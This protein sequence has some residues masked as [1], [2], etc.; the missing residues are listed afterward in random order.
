MTNEQWLI[1]L[2]GI[3]PNGG[4]T[5]IWA[6]ASMIVVMVGCFI[7]L[8][9]RDYDNFKN[10]ADE[11]YYK[12]SI[13]HK[14]GYWKITIPAFLFFAIMLSNL[15]PDKRTFMC[16]IAAPYVVE[17][18]KT[19]MEQLNDKTS[20]LHKLNKMLDMSLDKAIQKLEEPKK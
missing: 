15:I 16:I 2:Y 12:K 7:L 20:K 4:W 6:I 18:G 13:F 19:V 14:L 10:P 17:G 5:V 11:W 9:K 3:Y 8:D 1:Y